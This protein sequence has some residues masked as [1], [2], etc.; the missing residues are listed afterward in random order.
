VTPARPTGRLFG[1]SSV[2]SSAHRYKHVE[3]KRNLMSNEIV[4]A[5]SDAWGG[6]SLER[7]V[8]PEVYQD[9]LGAFLVHLPHQVVD[10]NTAAENGDVLAAQGIA[11]QI[12]GTASSFGAVRLDELAARMLALHGDQVGLLR[13]LVTELDAQVVDFRAV[14]AL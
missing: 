6:Q 9:L 14:V 8:G 3:H 2:R 5:D 4:S 1:K 7:D 13:S 11:H 12:K 10:L